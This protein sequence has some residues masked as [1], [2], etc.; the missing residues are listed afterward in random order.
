MDFSVKP[1][2]RFASSAPVDALVPHSHV[3][4]TPAEEQK[5]MEPWAG[6]PTSIEALL[7]SY[8]VECKI[9]GRVSGT[10]LYLVSAA[11]RNTGKMDS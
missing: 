3:D 1:C 10:T 9:P 11:N 7:A 5:S 8:N 4:P 6:E 2:L